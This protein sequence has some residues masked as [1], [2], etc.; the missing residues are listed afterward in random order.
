MVDNH[1]LILYKTH[2]GHLKRVDPVLVRLAKDNSKCRHE[3]LCEAY[4][5]AHSSISPLHNCC[6]VCDKKCECK[7]S[8]LFHIN[9]LCHFLL[10][11]VLLILYMV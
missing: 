10:V 7:H 1:N 9:I 4:L 8:E 2:K 5:V 11:E 3:L 6:D